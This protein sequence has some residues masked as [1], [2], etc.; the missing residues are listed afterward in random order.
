MDVRRAGP[1]DLVAA[2]DVCVAAY[3]PFTVGSSDFYIAEL[4]DAARRDRE[5]EVWVAV[6]GGRVLGCVTS[7]PPGSPWSEIAMG[8]E[9]GEFRMLAVDPAARGRGV[10]AA[11]VGRCEA[12]AR[13]HGAVGMVLSTLAEMASAHR[14]Y[15]RLGYRRAPERDWQPKPGIDLITYVKELS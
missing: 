15:E 12:R 3:A 10:G 4:R 9:E 6:E 2:G 7:C 11:L 5:A 8:P 14:L 1:D 13:A